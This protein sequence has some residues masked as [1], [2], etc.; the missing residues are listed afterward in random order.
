MTKKILGVLLSAVLFAGVSA[1]AELSDA[2]W[3]ALKRQAL[4]RQRYV[5]YDNDDDDLLCFPKDTEF[6]VENYLALRTS[7]LHN[8]PVDSMVV[9]ANYGAF[10]QLVFPNDCGELADFTWDRVKREDIR[11]EEQERTDC[12]TG[13]Q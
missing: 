11:L 7:F 10:Q 8:Y 9:N 5:I 13:A 4:E 6:T 3:T 2:E 12:R 1:A